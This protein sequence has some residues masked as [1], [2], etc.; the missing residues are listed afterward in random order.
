MNILGLISPVYAQ[1]TT[2]IQDPFVGKIDNLATL[3]TWVTNLILAIGL[4]MV[5]VMLAMG[6][7]KYVMSQGD[8]TAIE[9]AQKWVTF[10]AVGGIG[11]FLVYS[12][13]RIIINTVGS[14]IN[15]G[16]GTMIGGDVPGSKADN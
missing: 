10:A 4:S 14:N 8:K 6:F 12:A 16:Q 9:Q 2:E 13:R 11:L 3:F 15:L 5:V 7:M 1:V